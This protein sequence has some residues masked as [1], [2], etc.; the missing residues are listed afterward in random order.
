[1]SLYLTDKSAAR[2][3]RACPR[4]LTVRGVCMLPL[5]LSAKDIVDLFTF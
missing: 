2:S 4:E 5:I 3:T 1:M